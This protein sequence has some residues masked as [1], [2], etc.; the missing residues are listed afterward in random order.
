MLYL[1][2]G[3]G[4]PVRSQGTFIEDREIRDSV[5]LVAANAQAQYEPELVQ[6]KSV[7]NTDGEAVQDEMF[8]DAVRIVLE[9]QRGSVSLLQR[10]LNIGYGR[11]SRLIEL[12]AAS[13]ILGDYKGSQAR[14]VMLTL[15]DW[16]AMKGQRQKDEESGMTV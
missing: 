5:K 8:D 4:K 6:L 1:P 13:G 9:N 15:E 14:E 12:M 3:A 16:D 10:K 7:I 11:A 2:G